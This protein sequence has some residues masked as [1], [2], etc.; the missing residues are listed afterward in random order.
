MS[1]RNLTS[2]K[3]SFRRNPKSFIDKVTDQPIVV[4]VD[5]G[6]NPEYE[7]KID[8]R[9]AKVTT[10]SAPGGVNIGIR[11]DPVAGRDYD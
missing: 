2:N 6:V 4:A 7:I 10:S 1:R 8:P 9:T 11:R 3:R 5:D